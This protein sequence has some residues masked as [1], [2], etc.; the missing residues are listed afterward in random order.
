MEPSLGS[1]L[2]FTSSVYHAAIQGSSFGTDRPVPGLSPNKSS[3]GFVF[4]AAATIV[5]IFAAQPLVPFVGGVLPE[6]FDFGPRF[7]C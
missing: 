1:L 2:S 7:E 4:Q 5:G 3:A 6:W